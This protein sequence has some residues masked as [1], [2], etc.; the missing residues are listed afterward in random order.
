VFDKI[1]AGAYSWLVADFLATQPTQFTYTLASYLAGVDVV[2]PFA[3]P[4]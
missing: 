1:V 2:R 3:S 4:H